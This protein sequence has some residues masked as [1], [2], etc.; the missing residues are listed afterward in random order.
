MLLTELFN[1]EGSLGETAVTCRGVTV[2]VTI[3][4][5]LSSIC[6]LVVHGVLYMG[7]CDKFLFVRPC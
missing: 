3:I 2:T 1:R 6:T 4:L 5:S 7:S